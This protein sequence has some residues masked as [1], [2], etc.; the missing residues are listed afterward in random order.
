MIIVDEM[1]YIPWIPFVS[2][3]LPVMVKKGS[4]MFGISTYGSP[5]NFFTKL[6]SKRL[7]DGTPMFRQIEYSTICKKCLEKGVREVCKHRRGE[8]P[9]WHDSEEYAQIFQMLK[10]D[11]DIALKEL[12]GISVDSSIRPYFTPNTISDLSTG[13]SSDGQVCYVKDLGNA[14]ADRIYISVDPCGEGSYSEYGIV[15]C[16]FSD[17][18]LVV[19]LP[20][21]K[22]QKHLLFVCFFKLW[23]RQRGESSRASLLGQ[24]RRA[25]IREHHLASPAIGST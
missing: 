22:K 19:R 20:L 23:K 2:V 6:L 4:V 5:D 11:P 12:G 9:H 24:A 10:D 15:S 1:A 7:P 16:I 13:M 17:G 21:P 14:R 8:L 18:E 25:Q 3:I